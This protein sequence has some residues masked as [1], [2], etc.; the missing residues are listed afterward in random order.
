MV[1]MTTETTL[2][3]DEQVR[4]QALVDAVIAQRNAAL[5]SLAEAQSVIAVLSKK[6]EAVLSAAEAKTTSQEP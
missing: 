4:V 6:L 5:N 2:P 3:T 1:S